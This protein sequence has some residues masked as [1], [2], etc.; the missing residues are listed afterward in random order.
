MPTSMANVTTPHR[1]E[2][3]TAIEPDNP[4]ACAKVLKGA[5]L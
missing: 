4:V 2:I 1:T 3:S 5:A